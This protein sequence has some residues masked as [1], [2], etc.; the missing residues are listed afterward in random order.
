[1]P[2]DLT[3]LLFSLVLFH[4]IGIFTTQLAGVFGGTLLLEKFYQCPGRESGPNKI[5]NV[6]IKPSGK[7]KFRING[8]ITVGI[9]VVEPASII[10]EMYKCSDKERQHCHHQ[11]D[12]KNE[13]MCKIF[14]REG[15]P[16]T[17]FFEG[18]AIP[19]NCPIKQGTYS[20]NGAELDLTSVQ[21]LAFIHGFWKLKSYG[22]SRGKQWHCAIIEFALE[23]QKRKKG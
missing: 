16:W 6:E 22:K 8:T 18:I 2:S 20:L 10:V 13:D 19:P 9:P 12:F 7:N 14:G 1:M 21:T 15:M 5:S 17:S 11:V 3:V 23:N 4:S